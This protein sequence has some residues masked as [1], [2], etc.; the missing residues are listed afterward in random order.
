MEQY[1]E[2][3]H[4]PGKP[5]PSGGRTA[6]SRIALIVED[7]RDT[8]QLLGEHLRRWG[9]NPTVLLEGKPAISWVRHNKPDLILLDLLLPGMDGFTICENL[10]LERETNRIP[11]IMVTALTG[12]E[13]RVRGLQV[14]ANRYLT[15]PFTAADLSRAIQDAFTWREELQKRGSEG[16][17][18]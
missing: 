14:G 18:H 10:K 17:I 15:K 7:E 6:M 4:D 8:G 13:D 11:I 9:Y 1:G 3:G 2:A 16:E 12:H 5:L